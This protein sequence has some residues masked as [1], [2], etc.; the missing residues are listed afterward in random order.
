MLRKEVR[1]LLSFMLM[2]A[3][4]VTLL[5]AGGKMNAR[6]AE[7]QITRAF[8]LYVYRENAG[9]LYFNPWDN[10]DLQLSDDNEMSDTF[11]FDHKQAILQAVEEKA[12]W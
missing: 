7:E 11:G 5:P 6:A 3:M 9:K 4:M 10:S 2:V 12:D 1:K 8:T